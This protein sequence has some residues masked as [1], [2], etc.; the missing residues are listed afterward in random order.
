MSDSWTRHKIEGQLNLLPFVRWDRF[1]VTPVA[2][3]TSEF[4]NVYGWIDREDGRADFVALEFAPGSP[5]PS[6][7]TSSVARSEEIAACLYGPDSQHFDCARVEHH[8]KG[9]TNVVRAAS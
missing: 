4:F 2:D 7:L 6:F 3:L 5:S 1:V 8:F 9:A